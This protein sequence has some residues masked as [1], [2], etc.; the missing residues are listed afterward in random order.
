MDWDTGSYLCNDFDFPSRATQSRGLCA[1]GFVYGSH[2]KLLDKLVWNLYVYSVLFLFVKEGK[3]CGRFSLH[4]S[5]TLLM[6]SGLGTQRN[7]E[8]ESARPKV[9]VVLSSGGARGLSHI[10]VLKAFEERPERRS[11][12][13]LQRERV[14]DCLFRINLSHR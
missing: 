10:D 4:L 2:E 12:K 11:L 6:A 14:A 7:G 9:G 1:T 8:S 5:L 13:P 3:V